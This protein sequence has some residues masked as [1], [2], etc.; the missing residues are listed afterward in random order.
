MFKRLGLEDAAVSHLHRHGIIYI[1]KASLFVQDGTIIMRTVGFNNLAAGEYQIPYQMISIIALGPGSSLTHDVARI[2]AIHDTALVF[3]GQDFTRFYASVPFG[4]AL[5]DLARMQ[6]EK[7]SD[8]ADRQEICR[9][10]FTYRFDTEIAV[11]VSLEGLRGL[12]G[13]RV[14]ATYKEVANRLGVDWFGRRYDR[15]H[16]DRDDPPNRALNYVSSYLRAS[17]SLAVSSTNT[18]PQLGFIHERSD[19]AFILDIADLF[20]TE[21]CIEPAFSGVLRSKTENEPL[22]RSVRY[23]F[24]EASRK[25]GLIDLMIK[26]IKK[27]LGN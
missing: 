15:K 5:S 20:K 11:E 21:A 24:N 1:E 3:V 25:M 6:V 12:E 7:W 10:M 19:Q 14:K 22:E 27:I 2:C 4:R 26:S 8:L 9:K 18:I 23:T 17:A 13:K 16:P